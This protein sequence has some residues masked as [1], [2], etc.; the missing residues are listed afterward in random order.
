M[1][2]VTTRISENC[3][4]VGGF[5]SSEYGMIILN[6]W[7]NKKCSKPPTSRGCH[8]PYRTSKWLQEF[9]SKKRSYIEQ[10]E[11][12]WR[13]VRG[14]GWGLDIWAC[15]AAWQWGSVVG[16]CWPTRKR[17]QGK[18]QNMENIWKTLKSKRFQDWDG[19]QQSGVDVNTHWIHIMFS[20][21]LGSTTWHSQ[22]FKTHVEICS[23]N[24]SSIIWN[25]YSCRLPSWSIIHI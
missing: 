1:A 5:N 2:Q 19:S 22:S 4:L 3:R 9:L 11:L 17:L 25:K 12:G 15:R 20:P 13:C 8:G 10:N 7:E 6:I 24:K 14:T 21:I 23:K 18:E 16:W